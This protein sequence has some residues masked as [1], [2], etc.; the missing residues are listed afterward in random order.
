MDSEGHEF[1]WENMFVI[2]Q[3]KQRHAREFL[4]A[5]YSNRNS[6]NKHIELDPVYE[7]LRNR[8]GSITNHPSKPRHINNKRDKTPT[9]HRRR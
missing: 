5:W 9:L 4:E 1:N 8:T 6:T 7:P 2:A 3:A